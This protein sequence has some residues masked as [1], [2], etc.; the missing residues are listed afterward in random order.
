MAPAR[1][2]LHHN[3]R[4]RSQR[5]RW[6]LEEIGEPYEIVAV[7]LEAGEHKRPAFLALNPD[8]KL[9]TLI[10]RG[11]DGASAVVV[12]ESSAILLH[13]ADAYPEA[14][15]APLPGTLE[16]GRYLTWVC[17]A[18]AG[19][20]PALA[21]LVFPRAAPPPPM[22]IG[23]PT[24]DKALA[25][26]LAAVEPG[27][28][29]LGETFSAADVMVGALLGWIVSWGKLPEPERFAGYLGRLA[30]R[31]AYARAYGA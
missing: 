28:W 12:T 14:G 10:D 17:Y 6:L 26:V 22:A 3:P 23:W 31:P 1:F 11:P 8:G 5:I 20:E 21:D 15:L 18:A 19:L 2:V 29:L 7:D 24:F 25:R 4:S 30:A 9:P 13:V 27:P 16:R